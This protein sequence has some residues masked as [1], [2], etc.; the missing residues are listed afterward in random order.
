[1]KNSLLDM[2]KNRR[3][4]R[5][6]S[7]EEIPEELLQQVVAAGLLA[8]SGRNIRPWELVVVRDKEMI[9][10]LSQ[11]RPGGSQILAG[12]DAAIVVLADP[13]KTDVW[14]ED[15]SIVMSFMHLM[16]DSLGLGSCWIQ[17]RLRPSKE[18]G[19][20]A[21]DIVKELLGVP[22][23]YVLEATLCLGMPA[24]HAEART[25]EEIE[26]LMSEKVHWEKF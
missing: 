2:M 24:E 11:M 8:P 21:E 6:Y 20:M 18:D 17:G 15:C 14:T 26:K 19:K 13:L 10:K 23:N 4:V 12:A 5:R 9:E 25:E 22:E 7:G 3:S 1:M 16:A